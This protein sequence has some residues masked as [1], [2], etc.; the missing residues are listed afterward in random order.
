MIRPRW[1]GRMHGAAAASGRRP[2][3]GLRVLLPGGRRGCF[4][5]VSHEVAPLPFELTVLEVALG[6]VCSALARLTKELDAAVNAAL[7][8]LTKKAR[9]WGPFLPH[10]LPPP[11]PTAPRGLLC[12]PGPRAWG[13]ARGS[14]MSRHEKRRLCWRR[15]S[16]MRP[17]RTLVGRV[18]SRVGRPW[19]A[20]RRNRVPSSSRA[21]RAMRRRQ[22]VPPPNVC[23]GD[24]PQVT[25]KNLE[26]VRRVKTRHQRLLTRVTTV[27]GELERF[28]EDDDDMAKMCLTRRRDLEQQQVAQVGARQLSV[29]SIPCGSLPVSTRLSAFPSAHLPVHAET[30]A[31]A[32][33]MRLILG[34][35]HQQ[36][37]RTSF[38]GH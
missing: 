9:L 14:W 6:E 11:P 22:G 21:R 1:S 7:D 4:A 25:T 3:A 8:A 27:R 13:G 31:E 37:M 10:V 26:R 19:W 33:G 35:T 24:S 23:L 15:S 16:N 32:H 36:G 5:G 12:N 2:A 29:L 38:G 34:G 20:L 18:V 28:L 30:I 17:T